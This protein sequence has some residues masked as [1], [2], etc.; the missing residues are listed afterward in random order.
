MNI[1]F[2]FNP[3]LS[4]AASRW[5]QLASSGIYESIGRMVQDI[6]PI[7]L[8]ALQDEAPKRSGQYA[9]GIQS[10]QHGGEGHVTLEFR[11]ADPLST[12][13]IG[14][15]KPHDIYPVNARV[16]AFDAGGGMVFASH[17]HHPGTQP[18]DFVSRGWESVKGAVL[19]RLAQTGREI[20]EQVK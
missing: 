11:A 17:V 6:E 12:W 8:T 16:L 13:I 18:N 2:A 20:I 5:R 7:V 3:P 14:G 19:D 10:V 4:D 1:T 9:A 15:T